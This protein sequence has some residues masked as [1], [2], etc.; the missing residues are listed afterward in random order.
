ME[1][2]EREEKKKREAKLEE[3]RKKDEA[4]LEA[5]EAARVRA[6]FSLRLLNYSPHDIFFRDM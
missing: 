1:L 5:E 4:K 2:Q 3:Q 6:V